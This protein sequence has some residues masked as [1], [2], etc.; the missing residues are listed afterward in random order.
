M[1]PLNFRYEFCSVQWHYFFLNN[2]LFHIY[3]HWSF[4]ISKQNPHFHSTSDWFC[5]IFSERGG[6]KTINND[7]ISTMR[8]FDSM[9]CKYK[10]LFWGICIL[11]TGLVSERRDPTMDTEENMSEVVLFAFIIVWIMVFSCRNN[12]DIFFVYHFVYI[13]L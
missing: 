8:H 13:L 6:E 10:F 9:T 4:E 11:L 7:F 12:F 5:G 1:H 2:I 3:S